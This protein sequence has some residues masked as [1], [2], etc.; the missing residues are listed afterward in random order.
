MRK[1]HSV[2]RWE[3]IRN[4]KRILK[5][6]LPFHHENFQ[7]FGNSF[8]VNVGPPGGVMFTRD[9]KIIRHIL[10]KNHKNFEK[11][12]LQ[13]VDLAKY[14]GKG[15]LTSNGEHWWVHRRM[16]QP[17]FHKSK[18]ESLLGTM[19]SAIDQELD[20]IAP[21]QV[22][23]V[24]PLMSDLAFQVVAKSLFSR[25]DIRDRMN[26]LQE[27]TES[28]QRMLI[29]EM[30]Q[31]YLNWWFRWSGMINKYL[32]RADEGRAI[33]NTI[34]EERIA[35]GSENDDLLDML[36][37]AQYE[38]GT[39]MSR[40]QL[41]D[42]VMILFTA[43]HETTANALSFALFLLATRPDAQ[44]RIFE[45][46]RDIDY[47]EPIKLEVFKGLTYTKNALE[48]AM[49]IFPPVYVIDRVVREDD[50]IGDL[51]LKK[52]SLVLMSVYELHRFSSFWKDPE[53][54]RPERFSELAP[55]DYT[56]Y[57]YPFGAGPRMCIGNN[58]AM[59]EMMFTL[60]AI[61][62]K[63]RISTEIE[64][65]QINPLIS[66]KPVEVPVRFEVRNT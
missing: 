2:S 5:N 50:Q 41:I 24:Y 66:L 45:E 29:R 35:S 23:D 22:Q 39:Y 3:V 15:L 34:V 6:P 59:Y 54:F 38:D 26:K 30:R 49:R 16:I 42:E 18:L 11:S 60:S 8:R 13:T 28:C 61:L 62:T 57:Y 14:I 58:F 32:R 1:I 36:L 53:Q 37:N 4:R 21:N 43:G 56:E 51:H 63:Y 33:L 19:K 31:P 7:K 40:K 9:P 64:K 27:I 55:R 25:T 52:G 46:A 48:E 44:E 20:R 47:S 12:A 65:M 10:R 17:A